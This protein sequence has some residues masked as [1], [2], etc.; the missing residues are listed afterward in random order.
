M[1][2]ADS[3]ADFA[4]MGVEAKLQ[5]MTDELDDDHPAQVNYENGN[6][7]ISAWEPTIPS[8]SFLLSI[9]DTEV[10]PVAVTAKPIALEGGTA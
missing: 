8:G 3:V 9:H 4:A 5:F 7:D 1:S 6:P 10:G 2:E